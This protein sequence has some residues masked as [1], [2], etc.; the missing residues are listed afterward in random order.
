MVV[1]P[2]APAGAASGFG[3]G[4]NGGEAEGV[5]DGPVA[6]GKPVSGSVTGIVGSDPSGGVVGSGSAGGIVARGSSAP[7]EVSGGG[8]SVLPSGAA[9]SSGEGAGG[10]LASGVLPERSPVPVVSTPAPD[11][12]SGIGLHAAPSHTSGTTALGE[13]AID[14]SVSARPVVAKANA[15]T[16]AAV[17]I[18]SLTQA[19]PVD[20]RKVAEMFRSASLGVTTRSAVF[21]A[22]T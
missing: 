12:S 20:D 8:A 1:R 10:P 14:A 16:N 5:E 3:A 11:D 19:T 21:V 4:A 6:G 18:A 17:R 9:P 22:Q 13:S 2:S 7:G 15:T